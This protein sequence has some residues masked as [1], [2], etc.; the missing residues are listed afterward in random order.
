MSE[1]SE[2]KEIIRRLQKRCGT[3]DRLLWYDLM[4]LR[5]SLE[6]YERSE[7]SQRVVKARLGT[8]VRNASYLPREVFSR[9]LRVVELEIG[10]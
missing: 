4:R 3:G 1:F 5:T 8:A 9:G 10:S 6:R 7:V 2:A